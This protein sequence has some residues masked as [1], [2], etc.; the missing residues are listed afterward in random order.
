MCLLCVCRVSLKQKHFCIKI[1][2]EEMFV[3]Y[4]IS[5]VFR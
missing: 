1:Q 5:N 3:S 2:L 4:K